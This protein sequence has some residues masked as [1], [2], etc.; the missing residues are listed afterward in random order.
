MQNVLRA[1]HLTGA[2]CAA[3]GIALAALAGSAAAQP[4]PPDARRFAAD[5]FWVVTWARGFDKEPDL[6]IEPRELVISGGAVIVLDAGT[7][8]VL[9]LD[10]RTGRTLKRIEPRG[11]GPGEFRRPTSL[12][13]LHNGFGLLDQATQR[14]SA[15]N[16]DGRLL[17]D[18]PAPSLSG[19]A[20]AHSTTAITWKLSGSRNALQ[21]ID[22]SGR[23]RATRSLPWQHSDK[24]QMTTAAVAAGPTS[25]GECVF[26]R[27]FGPDFVILNPTG[28]QTQHRYIE[29]IPEP[30]IE[31][32]RR[33]VE[34]SGGSSVVQETQSVKGNSSAMKSV[35]VGDTLII[36][37]AG[38]TSHKY[39][40]LDY[41]LLPSGQ[42]LHSRRLFAP[43]TGFTAAPDGSIIVTQIG[44]LNS[45][46]SALRP[47]RTAPPARPAPARR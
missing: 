23:R 11:S 28:R 10:R 13:T 42:Y 26:A 8:E 1:L 30:V 39:R 27:V 14:F 37:F 2:R 18:I 15:L 24:E 9:V 33:T 45:G 29:A 44:E 43:V 40:L 5:S 38:L 46:I 32:K 16:L 3:T 7:R 36:Q 21:V 19:V 35:V 25:R 4:G 31:V 12:T 41:Y 6:V 17:W 34:K 20:C 22:T 47:S